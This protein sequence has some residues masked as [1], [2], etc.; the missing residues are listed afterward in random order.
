[1]QKYDDVIDFT[2]YKNLNLIL[3]NR[4]SKRLSGRAAFTLLGNRLAEYLTQHDLTDDEKSLVNKLV[5][6]YGGGIV[7]GWILL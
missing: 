4:A 1:M 3:R 2:E 7:D 6:A 5:A